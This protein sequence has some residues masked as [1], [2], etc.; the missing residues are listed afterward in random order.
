MYCNF[1]N[2]KKLCV[3]IVPIFKNLTFDEQLE[4]SKHAKT[5]QFEKDDYL[6]QAGD[7]KNNLYIIHKGSVKITRYTY[8][9]D[10]QVVRILKAGDF[11]GEKSFLTNKK[12]NEYAVVLE[13]SE[14][15]VIDNEDF[16]KHLENKPLIMFKIIEELTKRLSDLEQLVENINLLPANKRIIKSILSFNT[17]DINLLVSKKDWANSLGMSFETL[18]RNLNL[19]KKHK[20]INLIGQRNIKILDKNKLEELLNE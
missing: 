8:D 3:S 4:V 6:Y 16:K 11:I 20:L 7:I 1:H 10:E 13:K 14:I 5:K 9:G 17:D 15:C 2:N 19:L 12:S 18:S